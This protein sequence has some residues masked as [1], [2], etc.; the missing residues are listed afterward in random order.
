MRTV[1]P[2]KS[3]AWLLRPAV[4]CL[5][6]LGGCGEETRVTGPAP[7]DDRTEPREITIITDPDSTGGC[8]V[9]RFTIEPD[10]V[11][12][13]ASGEERALVEVE[14]QLLEDRCHPGTVP[15]ALLHF[16][17]PRVDIPTGL[18]VADSL[19][20]DWTLEEAEDGFACEP[21]N[22]QN[23]S[24]WDL[25]GQASESGYARFPYRTNGGADIDSTSIDSISV[26]PWMDDWSTGPMAA[27]P[28]VTLPCPNRLWLMN[29][30]FR[31][32]LRDLWE[33]SNPVTPG[34]DASATT[35]QGAWIVEV[36]E[37]S[38]TLEKEGVE[39]DPQLC[40]VRFR[41]PPPVGAV[42]SVHTHPWATG[43]HAGI[44]GQSLGVIVNTNSW[45]LSDGD[46]S[47]AQRIEDLYEEFRFEYVI[48]ENGGIREFEPP[49]VQLGDYPS[50]LQQ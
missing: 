7:V 3:V 48:Y 43:P 50:C 24:T 5:L 9:Y 30:S 1:S 44:C 25:S 17:G 38:Y 11:G 28:I 6:V 47:G 8:W 12:I 31:D 18:P 21:E 36:D 45:L 2:D 20:P 14:L 27:L 37:D 34:E 4:A 39:P 10:T 13:P 22:P 35:E 49:A 26:L 32:D 29:A 33:S 46:I 15:D 23:C 42:G 40:R 16:W 19:P 41:L